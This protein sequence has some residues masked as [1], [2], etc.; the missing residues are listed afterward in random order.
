MLKADIPLKTKSR[1]GAELLKFK[2]RG[3]G[4]SRYLNRRLVGVLLS[5]CFF[6]VIMGGTANFLSSSLKVL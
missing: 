6:A 3:Y 2:V 5:D 4:G 1:F